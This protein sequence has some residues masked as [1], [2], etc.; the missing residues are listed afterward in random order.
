MA[1]LVP[2]Y[3]TFDYRCHFRGAPG[4]SHD[5]EDYPVFWTVKV[6]AMTWEDDNDDEGKEVS[7]GEA[8]FYIVP[9]AGIIDLFLTLDAVS[10]EVAK[11][12][13]MLTINR[14]DLIEDM[15]LGGDLMVLSSLRISTRFRGI[16]LGH[17]ILKAVLCTV[18]RSTSKVILEAAPLLTK[19]TPAEGS[20]EHDL[21]KVA[22][23]HYWESFGFQLAHGDYLVFEDMADVLD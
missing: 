10:Q 11:V 3:L 14:P 17:T 1:D 12:G 19:K 16:K 23:R 18:G 5:L 7:V 21:A 2:E 20:A 9:D 4:A 13:E 15:A 22:L 8:N 6:K